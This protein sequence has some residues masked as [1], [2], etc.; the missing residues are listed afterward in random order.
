MYVI[1]ID[2]VGR[3]ALA[4]PLVVGGAL[5]ESN[6]GWYKELVR[7]NEKS[8]KLKLKEKLILK[9]SKKLSLKQRLRLYPVL[10]Q[11]LEVRLVVIEPGVI[12]EK[13]ISWAFEEGVNH[14]IKAFA[15]LI[16]LESVTVLVDGNYRL[17][18]KQPVK[19]LEMIIKGDERVGIIAAAAVVAKV[20]R[21]NLMQKLHQKWQVYGWDKN[22]GYGTKWHRQ[23]V[24]KHGLSPYHRRSFCQK[25]GI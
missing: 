21:D 4:G 16:E 13:G 2:E 15:N 20:Y 8:I 17:K 6:H 12:D 10:K 11:N 25:L 19:Q 7:I 9:D 5:I 1:G 3:G 22:V 14:I 18:L 23:A 24:L